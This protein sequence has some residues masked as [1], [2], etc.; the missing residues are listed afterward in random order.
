[1]AARRFGPTLGAGVVVIETPPDKTLSP[2]P[3]GITC[4]IGQ[5]EKGDVGEIIHCPGLTDFRKK[6]GGYFEGSQ[7]PD[8]AF[9]FYNLGQGAGQLYVV[10]VTDGTEVEAGDVAFGRTG[11]HGYAYGRSAD[12]GWS[13]TKKVMLT[14]TA[15]NG[16]RWAGRE[17]VLT[18]DVTTVATDITATTVV[19]GVT[20]LTDQYKG[21]RLSLEGV[22][23]TVY[24]VISN[25]S[26][27]VLTVE[28]DSTMAA[29]LAAGAS[30]TAKGYRVWL[31]TDEL[32]FPAS[33][34]GTKK[35]LA[36]VFKDGQE[37]E[38]NLFGLEV[39][40]S[41]VKVYEWANLSMDSTHK[42]WV[43]NVI[44]Q[45]A[46]NF[47][48]KVT[49]KYSGSISSATRPANFYGYAHDWSSNVLTFKPYHVASVV[50]TN[51][52]PGWV[53]DWTLPSSA[54]FNDRLVPLRL[55]LTVGGGGTTFTVATDTDFGANIK[56]LPSGTIGTAYVPENEH[57]PGFTVRAGSG[58]WTDGDIITIDVRPFPVDENGDGQLANTWLYY[59]VGTDKRARIRIEDNT[60]TTITL[61]NAPDTAPDENLTALLA[62]NAINTGNLVFPLAVASNLVVI[63]SHFGMHTLDL[64]TNSPYANAAALVAEINAKWQAAT[65]STGDIAA[66]G[67]GTSVDLTTDDSGADTNRGYD[68]FLVV[69]TA[70]ASLA[71]SAGDA[72]MG[73][74]G[75]A[76]RVQ[77]PTFLRNGYDGGTPADADYTQHF[78]TSTSVINRLVGRNLGLVKLAVPGKTSST[79]QRAGLSYAEFANYQYRVEFASTLDDD[80]SAVAWINDTIGRNDFGVCTYPSYGYV[81]NPQGEGLVVRTLT[82][83]I[84][85]REALVASQYQYQGY[86]KAAAGID[87]T[88]PNVAKL[89]TG[90]RILNEE[91]LNPQGVNIIKKVRGNYIIWG[92]R[93]ISSDPGWKW[94]HQREMM[95]H[96]ENIFRDQFDFIVF[97]I[98]D[99]ITRQGLITTFRAFFLPEWQKRALRGNKFEQAVSIKIDDDN[100]TNLTAAN[101]DLYADIKLRLADTVE[102]FNIRIGKA[103]I[104]E[105]LG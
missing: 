88:L 8:S 7:L 61:V 3:T 56:N 92:D 36:V 90:E 100:N 57:V 27:G 67:A 104:F 60:S 15:K 52:S 69:P 77:A 74:L 83:A 50:S 86:H 55:T 12:A 24:T 20:M 26:A 13:D 44:N 85:G 82:G 66:V 91:V 45:D 48:I 78:N 103:G 38:D 47:W 79:I 30:P 32:T 17:A 28:S 37:S 39:W 34:A 73:E 98:N 105:D 14:I 94:K 72:A 41:G 29:D 11:G 46:S 89:P 87:V 54:G 31:T 59:D 10:R 76:F 80:S 6:V 64:T 65:S 9:D 81:P 63:H 102:R 42:Y 53:D 84:H 40:E 51:A 25:T 18:G 19:T 33:V 43:E 49:A 97:A 75:A 22:S 99:N 93:T 101:G 95:S 35:G 16:G 5:A 21:A 1:M 23:D 62:G 96:Y 2:A 70:N 58:G 71:I 4:Y 68:S